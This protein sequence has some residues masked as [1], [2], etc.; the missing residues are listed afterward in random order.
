MAKD[1]NWAMNS[2]ILKFITGPFRIL[3]LLFTVIAII[4]VSSLVM[5]TYFH[6]PALVDQEWEQVKQLSISHTQKKNDLNLIV[7]DKTYSG[8]SFMFFDLTG[9]NVALQAS[10]PADAGY[11]FKKMLLKHY[12]LLRHLDATIKVIAIRIGNISLFLTLI[13]IV[14][15]TAL[16]D[17]LVQRAIRQKN[18]S[19]ESAGIY[20]RAKYWRVGIVWLSLMTY[21]ALPVSINPYWLVLPIFCMAI[22]MFLQAKYLKKY[23]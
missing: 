22:L 20:H 13:L 7:A 2:L 6:Q 12:D 11:G 4:F 9:I 14:F 17:G 10:G 21:L 15:I 8:L 5:Q 18:A 16:I 1:N 19:R 23:L 3:W